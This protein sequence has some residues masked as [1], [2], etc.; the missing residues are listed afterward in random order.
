MAIYSEFSHEKMVIFQSYVDVYQSVI[1][2]ST[3][4]LVNPDHYRLVRNGDWLW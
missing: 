3:Q 4:M 1:Q 2:N